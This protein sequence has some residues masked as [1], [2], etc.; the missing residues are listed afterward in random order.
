MDMLIYQ[1]YFVHEDIKQANLMYDKNGNL[2]FI[3]FGWAM[4]VYDDKNAVFGGT[5]MMNSPEKSYL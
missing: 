4:Q 5:P 3:D 2:Y 1:I